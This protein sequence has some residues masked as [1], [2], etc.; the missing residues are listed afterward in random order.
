MQKLLLV[1]PILLTFFNILALSGQ[2][3]DLN[4]TQYFLDSLT[5]NQEIDS[6]WDFVIAYRRLGDCYRQKKEYDKALEYVLK[7]KALAEKFNNSN[8]DVTTLNFMYLADLYHK[9]GNPEKVVEVLEG[10]LEFTLSHP[11]KKQRD[12]IE[13]YFQLGQVMSVMNESERAIEYVEKAIF[14][15][16]NNSY[17]GSINRLA[18]LYRLLGISYLNL[19]DQ[20]KAMAYFNQCLSLSEGRE[21]NMATRMRIT[22]I[23]TIGNICARKKEY[24]LAFHY[25]EMADS[26]L[27]IAKTKSENLDYL[28][29]EFRGVRWNRAM[30]CLQNDELEQAEKHFLDIVNHYP[31][32]GQDWLDSG[33]YFYLGIIHEWLGNWEKAL[34]YNHQ[35]IIVSC[36]T[37]NID[38]YFELPAYDDFREL[39]NIYWTLNQKALY[40]ARSSAVEDKKE[41][42]MRRYEKAL[43]V[44]DMFDQLHAHN[45][46]KMNLL[47]DGQSKSLIETSTMNFQSALSITYDAYQVRSD[48]ITLERGFYYTEKMK[49]QQLWLSLLNSNA[50]S[51]GYL[52]ESLLEQEKDLLADIN[53][54]ETE[55]YKAEQNKDT[56]A[57]EVIK[58]QHL[59]KLRN[60]YTNLQRTLEQEYPD[61]FQAK[62]KFVPETV[63]SLQNVL[64]D[65]ELLVEYVF[66]DTALFIYTL[67]QSC[68]LQ[69]QKVPLD[70]LTASRVDAFNKR[71][72]SSSWMRRSSREKFIN[73]SYALYRQFLQP[74]EG[75]LSGKNRLIIIGDGMTN[76]IPFEVLL[77][78][79]EVKSFRELDYLIKKHEVSYHY[80]ASLFAKARKE[81]IA[82]TSGIFAFAPVYDYVDETIAFAKNN[83]SPAIANTFRAFDQDGHYAPLP[84]SEREVEEIMALFKKHG[85]A[86]SK[87]TL[88]AAAN[89]MALK[90]NLEKPYRFVHI[91]GHS[92]ADLDNP[93]FSGIA[94]LE[95]KESARDSTILAEDGTLY[96]GEIYNLSTK[97]DLVTLS[98]CESGYGK[99]EVSEGLLGLNRAF[100]YTGTPNVIF[101]LWKVYDKVSAE[102]MVDF[103]QYVLAGESY[104][105]SLRQAKL[106]LLKQ[107]AT[108][109]PHF[110]GP[111]LLIGR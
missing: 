67:A 74:I 65:N 57:I 111:Y 107:E 16:K 101:S 49:A 106:N 5:R 24:P 48:E 23:I 4:R 63:K 10:G 91:A 80:S 109:A 85:S 108:A 110:W 83:T 73:L 35:A 17:E 92:F 93:K 99:M 95:K 98:S 22:S 59:F 8:Y 37:F 12:I 86:D 51:F 64:N 30:I 36:K 21:G 34:K 28:I 47:R 18:I 27:Q 43:E 1:T 105:T 3:L 90:S 55:L 41:E 7:G 32:E 52:E 14:L 9:T 2:D 19:R 62:Y 69:L 89:E 25:L 66:T 103:Y 72:Q 15:I 79:D 26:L 58:N 39:G 29:H 33:T 56:S 84:E 88:R 77:P 6:S 94:C 54:Y 70:T 87:L 97:A 11:Q 71:L 50:K 61:Y 81:V 20:E 31:V 60:T 13:Y 82:E 100:I 75:Q 42:K 46:K 102:L 104:T 78:S 40:L 45:L 76:Y 44:S 96:T 53:H 38:D 68:S